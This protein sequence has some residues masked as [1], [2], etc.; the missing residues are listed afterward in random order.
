MRLASPMGWASHSL[1]LSGKLQLPRLRRLLCSQAEALCH[2]CNC[3]GESVIGLEREG[4][5]VLCPRRD[6]NPA[7]D[8]LRHKSSLVTRA[9]RF[10]NGIKREK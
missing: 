3:A 7:E 1:A 8:I 4:D 2:G 5:T 9:D 6:H 10:A